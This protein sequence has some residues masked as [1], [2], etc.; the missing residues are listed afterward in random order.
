MPTPTHRH[1]PHHHLPHQNLMEHSSTRV[2]PAAVDRYTNRARR[3]E[4][5]RFGL[6]PL[7]VRPLFGEVIRTR[8]PLG[9]APWA[10]GTDVLP[11]ALAVYEPGLS[12]PRRFLARLGTSRTVVMGLRPRPLSTKALVSVGVGGVAGMMLAQ[13][14]D[15]VTFMAPLYGL[16]LGGVGGGMGWMAVRGRRATT[17]AVAQWKPE[18]DAISR[19]LQNADRI[20]Q[21]FLSPSALRASLHSALWHAVN[22]VGQPGEHDVIGAFDEQLTALRQATETTLAELESPSIANRKA[23]VSERLATAVT[24][25]ELTPTT[26]LGEFDGP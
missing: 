16:A 22:A 3:T 8:P 4:H 5:Q 10:A 23:A 15:A 25:L 21:P 26:V 17:I 1:L 20:G 18:L 11:S 14:F 2:T 13:P 7:A 24:E 6:S 19:I 9:A 12:G